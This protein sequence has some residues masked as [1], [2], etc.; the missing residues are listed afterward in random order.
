METSYSVE[1]LD[2]KD[3]E[4][5]FLVVEPAARSLN[6]DNWRSFCGDVDGPVRSGDA[7]VWVVT[8]RS[9]VVRGVAVGRVRDHPVL[10]RILD[11]P[12]FTMASAADERGIARALTDYLRPLAK[13]AR[14]S[15]IRFWAMSEQNWERMDRTEDIDR[16]DSG[17]Q[18][19]V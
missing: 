13:E 10:G 15:S 19:I 6:L 5:S 12:F 4:K 9:R 3:I 2:D 17:I 14:C 11:V 7:N 1:L 16:Y 8:S 18:F